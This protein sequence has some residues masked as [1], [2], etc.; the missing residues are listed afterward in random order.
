MAIG[1]AKWHRKSIKRNNSFSGNSNSNI[2]VFYSLFY[3]WVLYMSPFTIYFSNFLISFLFKM[4][5]IYVLDIQCIGCVYISTYIGF[6]I[7]YLRLLKITLLCVNS[8][9]LLLLLLWLLFT[10]HG[11]MNKQHNFQF[12]PSVFQPIG[13]IAVVMVSSMVKMF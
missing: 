1:T 2:I 12:Y 10:T 3:F 4:Q 6:I 7:E 11:H 9:I 5:R 8:K 13:L